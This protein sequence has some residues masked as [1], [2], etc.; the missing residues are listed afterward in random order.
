M[1]QQQVVIDEPI[2]YSEYCL[3]V[4]R[5][6]KFDQIVI[7]LNNL[8]ISQDAKELYLDYINCI[9]EAENYQLLNVI[10]SV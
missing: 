5:N 10:T 7:T 2:S 1:L 9:I 3:N 6:I 4:I 8:I